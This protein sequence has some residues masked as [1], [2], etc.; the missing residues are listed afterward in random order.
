ME[1]LNEFAGNHPQLFVALAVVIVMLAFSHLRT[2]FQNFKSIGP[3]EATQLIN[4]SEALVLDIR[5]PKELSDGIIM[6]SMHVPLG[7]LST[8]LTKLEKYRDRPIIAACRSGA[9]SAM[10]CSTLS[11]NGFEQVYNLRGGIIAWQNANLPLAK[12]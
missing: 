8:S 1:Q 9:R 10:A 6:D 4:Q 11:K 12:K 3:T 2:L 7:Q 5:E